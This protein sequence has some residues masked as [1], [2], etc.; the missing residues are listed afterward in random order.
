[1][2]DYDKLIESLYGRVQDATNSNM[3][4][5][6]QSWLTCLQMAI[7]AKNIANQPDKE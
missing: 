3:V 7:Q 4:S 2:P 5:A 6:A 1:M